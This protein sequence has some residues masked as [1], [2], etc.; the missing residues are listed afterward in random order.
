MTAS[1]YLQVLVSF[2]ILGI[3]LFVFYKAMLIYK[4]KAQK[5]DIS[6]KERIVVDSTTNI[7][8]VKYKNDEFLLANNQKNL[9]L[10]KTYKAS[11]EH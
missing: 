2:V 6:L 10:L 11:S 1:Y 4:H 3:L 9:L 7:T 5:G 8:L